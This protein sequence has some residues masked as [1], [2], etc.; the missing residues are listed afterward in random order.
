MLDGQTDLKSS[1]A[2]AVLLIQIPTEIHVYG[3]KLLSVLCIT[4]KQSED[5]IWSIAG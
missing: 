4:P 1:S 5:S 2:L 3:R